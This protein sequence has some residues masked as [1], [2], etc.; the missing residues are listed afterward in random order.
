MKK[1]GPKLSGFFR[2]TRKGIFAVLTRIYQLSAWVDIGSCFKLAANFRED[3]A[4]A[5]LYDAQHTVKELQA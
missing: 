2:E 1:G 5:T 3:K 4:E